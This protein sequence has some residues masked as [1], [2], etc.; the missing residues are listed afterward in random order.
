MEDAEKEEGERE[1]GE[2]REVGEMGE[3]GYEDLG[4]DGCGIEDGDGDGDESGWTARLGNLGRMGQVE[5]MDDKGEKWDE[6]NEEGR[7]EH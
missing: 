5:Y 4:E 2:S 3:M 1:G 7:N 6:G